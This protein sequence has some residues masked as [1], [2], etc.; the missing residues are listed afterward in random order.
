MS[1]SAELLKAVREI[2][3]LL[4]V[5]AEPALAERDA[6]FRSELKRLVGA[7]ALKAKA[8]SL[9]KGVLSQREIH[10]ESGMHEG[11]LS[12]FIK[13]L[14]AS[15]LLTDDLNPTLVIAI[16]SNFFDA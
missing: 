7:S 16:P 6:K 8:A 12:T 15:N 1:E 3:E 4:E 10:R 9:M 11:N 14:R 5:M 2:R 13:Q